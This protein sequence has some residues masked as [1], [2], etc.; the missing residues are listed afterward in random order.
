MARTLFVTVNMYYTEYTFLDQYSLFD[1]GHLVTTR[2]QV[3][4]GNEIDG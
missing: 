1:N 4:V 2:V 3:K